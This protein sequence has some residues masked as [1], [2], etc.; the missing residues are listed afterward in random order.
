MLSG[1]IVDKFKSDEDQAIIR[2]PEMKDGKGLQ[3]YINS[4]IEE[5]AKITKTNKISFKEE[6][7]WLAEAL[8]KIEKGKKVQLI[9]EIDGEVVGSSNVNRK[10]RE[11]TQ[12]VG[13][14]GIGLKQD[15]REKGLGKKLSQIVLKEARKELDLE[16]IK[17][18][19]YENNEV[20][21]SLYKELGFEEVGRLNNG[22]KR[23]GKYIDLL[24]FEKKLRNED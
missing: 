19:A 7:D 22:V 5:G 3:N 12:H 2:Y 16:I 17:L 13:N 14:F 20:A 23:D 4:L 6:V 9:L 18:K 24:I 21:I 11:P 8:K 1:K 15:F 10:D